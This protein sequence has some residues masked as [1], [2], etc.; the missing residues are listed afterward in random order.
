MKIKNKLIFGLLCC[1]ALVIGGCIVSGT[2]VVVESFSFTPNNGFYVDWIDLTDNEDWEDHREN[3][4]DIELVGFELWVTNNDPVDWSFYAFMDEYDTTCVDRTCAE[5]STTKF[6]VFD[7]LNVPGST[8]SQSVKLVSYAESFNHIANLTQIQQMVLD[9]TFN[10][11]G[12]VDGGSGSINVIDS[13]KVIITVNAS[14][15]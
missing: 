11:Y 1:A 2:F 10:F 12:F 3:I 9:G 14:D 6:L 5:G 15:T 13:I 8:G 4:D 7:T